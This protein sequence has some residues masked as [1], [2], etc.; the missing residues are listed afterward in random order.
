MQCARLGSTPGTGPEHGPTCGAAQE[1][2]SCGGPRERGW[3]L[4][5]V[6]RV[7]VWHHVGLF[8]RG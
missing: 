2:V 7:L 8:K 3:K 4:K 6:S 5:L 1:C